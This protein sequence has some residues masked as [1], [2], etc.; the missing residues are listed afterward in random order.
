AADGCGSGA[1]DAP[2]RPP[3]HSPPAAPA[4]GRAARRGAAGAPAARNRPVPGSHPHPA[5]PVPPRSRWPRRRGRRPPS[6]PPASRPPALAHP[7]GRAARRPVARRD[8][9]ATPEWQQ[10]WAGSWADSLYKG[11]NRRQAGTKAG[12]HESPS[13]RPLQALLSQRPARSASR[14]RPLP[15]GSEFRLQ[16]PDREPCGLIPVTLVPQASDYACLARTGLPGR[17]GTLVVQ[18]P[19]TNDDCLVSVFCS[20][21]TSADCPLA[22]NEQQ[23][24]LLPRAAAPGGDPQGRPEPWSKPCKTTIP[25]KPRNGWKPWSR[26]STAKAR[27][28]PST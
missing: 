14:L 11:A 8:R 13:R 4:T 2:A 26:S 23:K 19:D 20:K 6:A 22:Y 5:A 9:P 7:A 1:D 27:S 10:D 18:L 28:A 16:Q 3:G 12:R 15:A 24:A 17:V 21:T 25:S